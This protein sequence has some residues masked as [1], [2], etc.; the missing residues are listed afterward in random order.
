MNY[1]ARKII[2][3]NL[4]SFKSVY[5][6]QSADGGLHVLLGKVLLA[7]ELGL[8]SLKEMDEFIEQAFKV[9]YEVKMLW[10]NE[11]IF[12]KKYFTIIYK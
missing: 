1:Q 6:K 12:C 3:D 7:V 10:Q 11:K 2:I 5:D 8:I 9:N 4:E